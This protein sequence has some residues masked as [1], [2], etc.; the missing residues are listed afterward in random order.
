MG[1]KPLLLLVSTLWVLSCNQPQDTPKETAAGDAQTIQKEAKGHAHGDTEH[2]HDSPHGGMVMSAGDKHIELKISG[3]DHLDVYLLD[4][5]TKTLPIQGVTGKVKLV[6]DGKV[7]ELSLSPHEDHLSATEPALKE[8]VRYICPMHPEVSQEEPGQCPSCGME[9]VARAEGKVVAVV[10]LSVEGKPYSA[11]FTYDRSAAGDPVEHQ[12]DAR[13]GGQVGMAGENH[14]EVVLFAP[15][16]YRIYLSDARRAPLP[17]TAAKDARLIVDPDGE[18][19]EE[20]T[21]SAEP[22]GEFLVARGTPVEK[23]PVPV[24]V[25]LTLSGEAVSME[26]FLQNASREEK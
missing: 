16:E 15:G 1:R 18:A 25:A 9:L 10:D 8:G 13:Q 12:H 23:D 20:L 4:E 24:K 6:L 22:S 3:A 11:R 2:D 17:A 19:P 7:A 26:F 5:E 14:L 21:L